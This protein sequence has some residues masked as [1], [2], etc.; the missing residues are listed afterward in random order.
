MTRVSG[1]NS[2]PPGA[3][4]N[5]EKAVD[6]AN[7]RV[8]DE[9]LCK[10]AKAR[11]DAERIL[12]EADA[13]SYPRGRADAFLN[14]GWCD[15][16]LSRLSDAFEN[17]SAAA[18][19]YDALGDAEGV[20]KALNGI[21]AYYF[22]ISRL[23]KAVD[24]FTRSLERAR[25]HGLRDREVAAMTNIG[26]LC[27]ELG[28]P[29]EALDYL[30][31]AYD[32]QI[33]DIAGEHGAVILV[34]IGRAFLEM[35]N[36]QLA[37]EFS[38]KALAIAD[39]ANEPLISA[40]S[41][42][43][44]ARAAMT[45][46]MFAEAETLLKQ[47]LSLANRTKSPRLRGNVLI[48][49]GRLL[50]EQKKPAEA[51][52]PLEEAAS[53]CDDIKS[54]KSMY[55]AFG[56]LARAY[57]E[58]K[59]HEKAL[60]YF[61]KFSYYRAEVLREDTAQKVRSIQVQAE[62]DRAQQQA[63]IYRLR[64]TE[65]KD[66]T[67]A[68]EESNRQIT[69][70]SEIGR[71]VTASLSF[72]TVVKT[73]YESLKPLIDMDI[74]GVALHDPSARQ[75]VYR[76]FYEDGDLKHDRSV[77]DD[78]QDSFAAWAFMHRKPV[79][80]ANKDQEYA[81]YLAQP[82][83]VRGKPCQSI[84]CLPL[85]VEN[86]TLGVL[87]AQNYRANAYTPGHLT[88]LE[89][90]T[91][92]VAIAVENA[93]IHDRLEELNKALSEEK[94]RLERATLK[95]SHLANHDSLTGLPNRRLL[96]EL[97]GK[98]LETSRRSGDLVGVA[99]IDLDDFKPV[100]DLWGHAAGD[101][102]LV[103]MAERIKSTLRASDIVARVGGDEFIAVLTSVK[104]RNDI[105]L[106]ARKLLDE[107]SQPLSFSGHVR[108]FGFSMGISV[109]PD[110]AESMEDLI[111]KADSAMYRVKRGQKRSFAFSSPG[112]ADLSGS[113]EQEAGLAPAALD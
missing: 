19:A 79:L 76:D 17:L 16:H 33:G 49:L 53:L 46:G 65:L 34:N 31:K 54:K 44:L 1:K 105:E 70:I 94:K 51:L 35:G 8:W 3:P 24:Y 91:P 40:E 89:A 15:Y 112:D 106:V 11:K 111:N 87:M 13:L 60:A 73:L 103:A 80:M 25:Q 102:A 56:E 77:A 14:L 20:C 72:H 88:L 47:A 93:L 113:K 28:N 71:K 21:G 26:E 29:K 75:L 39:A 22:E 58:L 69:S 6:A 18:E 101:S 67:D 107:C 23:D 98:T 9:L 95:I 43:T 64:N 109:Y 81:R 96:F 85:M 30:L 37:R 68:L 100:N 27:I 4:D 59:N 108:S 83:H 74:F 62:I 61:K 92:Y 41:K 5:P 12:A 36:L 50:L 104:D 2:Q 86:R 52:K 99:F 45:E 97:V 10:P 38:E 42:E 90:L 78:A 48:A 7:A 110:D 32:I 82:S 55:S 63:E 66:K 57:E 84:A